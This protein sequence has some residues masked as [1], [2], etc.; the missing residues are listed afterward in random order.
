MK[1]LILCFTLLFC[2]CCT[3]Q[4][5]EKIENAMKATIL[6]GD[7]EGGGSGVHIG[8]NKILTAYHVVEDKGP[9][10]RILYKN[11]EFDFKI[12]KFDEI[13]DLAIIE[14][15]SEDIIISEVVKI[16]KKAPKIGDEI[17]SIGYH[18]AAENLKT[19][20]SG[21]ISG[22]MDLDAKELEYD[23]TLFDAAMNPGCSGGPVLNSDFEIIGVNQRGYGN[24]YIRQYSG[25]C[26]MNHFEDFIEF[27]ERE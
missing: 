26:G 7:G 21:V 15:D 27:M 24:P 14:L 25:V 4:K 12:L 16:S 20:S 2:S 17:R 10:L 6:I 19:C 3:Q 18:W 9:N 23:K 8:N 13:L 22:F 11:Q 1:R 5:Y